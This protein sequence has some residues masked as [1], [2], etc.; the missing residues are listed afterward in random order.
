MT[1]QSPLKVIDPIDLSGLTNTTIAEPD[2]SVGEAEWVDPLNVTQQTLMPYTD[3][4]LS[5]TGD[6]M[7]YGDKVYAVSGDG[8]LMIYDTSTNTYT[9]QSVAS[10]AT[11]TTFCNKGC[12]VGS[13]LYFPLISTT[14]DMDILVVDASDDSYATYEN[15]DTTNY[16]GSINSIFT[17]DGQIMA[18]DSRSHIY[19]FGGSSFSLEYSIEYDGSYIS[20][21][22]SCSDSDGNIVVVATNQVYVYNVENDTTTLIHDNDSSSYTDYGT[23]NDCFVYNGTTYITSYLYLLK[24]DSSY[25][26]TVEWRYGADSLY[27]VNRFTNY[28]FRAINGRL[29][30]AAYNRESIDDADVNSGIYSYNLN[31]SEL[32]VIYSVS[33]PTEDFAYR[34]A[35]MLADSS[36]FA[37]GSEGATTDSTYAFTAHRPYITGEEAILTSTHLNYYC[38]DDYVYE[39][40]L[41]GATGEDGATW[42]EIGPT[43]R[44]APFDYKIN[45]K[46]YST[47]DFYF[48]LTLDGDVTSLSVFGLEN[49]YQISYT[50]YNSGGTSIQS[51]TVDLEDLTPIDTGD[52]DYNDAIYRQEYIWDDIPAGYS[53]GYLRVTFYPVSGSTGAVGAICMGNP[54]TIGDILYDTSINRVSYSTI[55]QDTFGNLSRTIRDSADYITYEV[56]VPTE[57]VPYV[58]AVLK[59]VLDQDVVW[60]GQMPSGYKLVTLGYYETSPLSIPNYSRSDIELKINGIV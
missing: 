47:S 8:E 35:L 14:P 58:A 10:S 24:L 13:K 42:V 40:P 52:L 31:T 34:G 39:S 17:L 53:G 27:L 7:S 36:V 48:D 32:D 43:N 46:T 60:Y 41:D 18:S 45:T 29:T 2:T 15:T 33:F 3:F 5:V 51:E 49:I 50:L 12:A 21:R 37:L 22:A 4:S 26:I 54:R 9:S 23:L 55:E 56:D 1:I 6:M 28:R 38:A 11:T 16:S 59:S 57:N 44:W 19:S 25:N 20:Q 30:V